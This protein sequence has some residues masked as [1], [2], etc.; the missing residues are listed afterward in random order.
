MRDEVVRAAADVAEAEAVVAG[1]TGWAVL[2][3]RARVVRLRT[4]KKEKVAALGRRVDAAS[5][6][7]HTAADWD[8][9]DA[10]RAA[11]EDGADPG[12]VV[13]GDD[14][15]ALAEHGNFDTGLDHFLRWLFSS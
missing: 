5:Q 14:A 13:S 3:A 12:W 11:L 10:V 4:V 6:R 2:A 7:L 15:S 9:L 8:D 1:S